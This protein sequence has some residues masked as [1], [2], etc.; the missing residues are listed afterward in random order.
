[1][2]RNQI[3]YV[4]LYPSERERFAEVL[5]REEAML[6][7][8][9]WGLARVIR[10]LALDRLD[11]IAAHHTEKQLDWEKTVSRLRAGLSQNGRIESAAARVAGERKTRRPRCHHPTPKENGPQNR[12]IRQS[13]ESDKSDKG[14]L[15]VWSRRKGTKPSPGHERYARLVGRWRQRY[16][17]AWIAATG[18]LPE[19]AELVMWSEWDGDTLQFHYRLD[20][21][22]RKRED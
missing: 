14:G 11:D 3:A 10:E 15:K 17:S 12:S 7:R 22:S 9:D 13:D 5:E 1:M 18:V 16:L 6:E 21:R 4:H 8:V 20:R 2:E 19:N